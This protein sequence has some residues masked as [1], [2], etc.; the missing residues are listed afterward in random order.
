MDKML[1]AEAEQSGVKLLTGAGLINVEY[2]TEKTFRLRITDK[3]REYSLLSN[4]LVDATGRKA[5]LSSYFNTE[6]IVFDRLI[7]IAIKFID[8]EAACN[9]FT[10]VETAE[11]GW[12]Y[13]APVGPNAS[14]AMLM[15]D[16]DIAAGKNLQHLNSWE[17]ALMLTDSTRSRFIKKKREWGP[18]I[19]S[20]VTQRVVRNSD[21]I[22]PF[23]SVGDA[24]LS[25]DPISGSG[26]I[27]ALRTAKEAAGTIL[28]TLGGDPDSIATYERN[29]NEDCHKYLLEWASYYGIEHRWFAAT[30]WKRRGLI[31]ETYCV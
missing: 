30:F 8:E 10:M 13:S 4:F 14:I 11:D 6:K 28:S 25:V 29:R 22:R 18:T 23:I 1:A 9:L 15:T 27:R 3:T 12:W 17:Q 19:F 21:D 31:Q 16:G 26:V 7:G 20:A 24:A 2:D 5:M